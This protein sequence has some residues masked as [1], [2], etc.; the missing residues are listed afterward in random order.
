MSHLL[1]VALGGGLGA[2]ARY[3]TSHAL[4]R[5]AGPNFPFGTLSVN[6]FGSFLMGVLIAILSRRSGASMEIRSFLA[7]GFL[8][9]FTTFSAFSL[10][11]VLM[12]ER[13]DHWQSALYMATS[14][15]FSILALVAGLA[16]VR[17]MA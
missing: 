11:F 14:V 12:W 17:A 4:L 16:L 9:G 8:G 6:I 7:T 13:G 1:L 3:L 15:A 2:S 10:D 5:L